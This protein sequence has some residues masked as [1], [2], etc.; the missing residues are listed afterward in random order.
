MTASRDSTVT[1]CARAFAQAVAAVAGA[2]LV[3]AGS[4]TPAATRE[5]QCG[6]AKVKSL[7]YVVYAT[8]VPCSLARSWVPR[9]VVQKVKQNGPNGSPLK[10]PV[11]YTCYANAFYDQYPMANATA[12]LRRA[13]LQGLSQN[14]GNC[15]S[16]AHVL[17][18]F[19]WEIQLA[20]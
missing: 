6:N 15:G 7:T 19:S 13:R 9:L 2:A 16:K 4:A 12:L 20:P 14:D 17:V 8:G 18:K 11:G 3:W 1:P 10:G 5:V